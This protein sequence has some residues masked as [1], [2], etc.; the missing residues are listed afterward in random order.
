M[1]IIAL[2]VGNKRI[3][4]ATGDTV[5]KI[6][7][8]K[9]TFF[10]KCNDTD[11]EGIAKIIKDNGAEL[12]VSGYPLSLDGTK[13]YQTEIVEKFIEKLKEYITV[14][15]VFEDERLTTVSAEDILLEGNVSRKDRKKVVDKIAASYILEQYLNKVN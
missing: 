2:D 9:E 4:I 10:R 12:V 14:P 5:F 15:V 7:F 13:S 6:A 1:K 11:Y 3:G 8:P